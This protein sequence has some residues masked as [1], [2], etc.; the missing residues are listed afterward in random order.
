[1][2]GNVMVAVSWVVRL[3]V[4]EMGLRCAEIGVWSLFDATSHH[5]TAS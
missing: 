3:M 4:E 2:K 5:G 1:M